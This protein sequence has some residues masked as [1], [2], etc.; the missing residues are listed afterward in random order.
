MKKNILI[1]H[2]N[3]V[4]GGVEKVTLNILENLSREKFN[5]KVVL[6]EKHGELIEK[7]PKD[8]EIIYLLDKSYSRDK[9]GLIKFIGYLKELNF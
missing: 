7:L 5:I 8:L 6:I 1:F 3:M 4:M 2:Q 9:K